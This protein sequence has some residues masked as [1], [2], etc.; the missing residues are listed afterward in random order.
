MWIV[1]L[2]T[3]SLAFSESTLAQ[4][5]KEKNDNFFIGGPAYYM[6]SAEKNKLKSFLYAGILIFHIPLVFL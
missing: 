4:L 3:A 2:I 5:Y 6:S 1:A